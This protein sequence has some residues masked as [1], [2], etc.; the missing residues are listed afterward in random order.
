MYRSMTMREQQCIRGQTPTNQRNTEAKESML[1][2]HKPIKTLI[3][4]NS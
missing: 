4:E 3:T 1:V 2:F